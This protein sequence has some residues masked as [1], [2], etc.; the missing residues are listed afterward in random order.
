MLILDELPT[1]VIADIVM[2][3]LNPRLYINFVECLPPEICLK[4]LGYLDPDS[5]I[6][7]AMCCRGWYELAIDRKLWERLF[8][9]EGWKAIPSEILAA[10]QRMNE[11]IAS[12]QFPP[13]RS[14]SSEDG[15]VSKK[16]G[17]SDPTPQ[18]EDYEMVDADAP[19]LQERISNINNVRNM[20]SLRTKHISDM[21][22]KQERKSNLHD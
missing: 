7:V 2:N 21:L 14:Q 8:Y 15:H 4:I 9:L 18:D 20:P 3:E 11:G 12:S 19:A 10:E 22:A 1:T 6:H 17:V 13:Q 16:R 5:L